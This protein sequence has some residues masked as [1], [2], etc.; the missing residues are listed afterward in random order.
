MRRRTKIVATL[1]PAVAS[2]EKVE[3]LIEAG[4]N[5]AR[6][7]CSHGDWESKREF[8]KWVR[9][10]DQG[11]SPVAILVDL[12]GPKFRI[13]QIQDGQIEVVAGDS[14]TIGPDPTATI[15]APESAVW[16]A[17]APGDRV[18]LG[19]GDVELRIE[20]DLGH[21]LQATVVTSGTIKSRQGVTLVG[22]SFDAPALTEKDLEDVRQ[23]V[24]F[25]ADYI[26]LSYVRSADDLRQ[27]RRVVEQYSDT[28]QIVA[29]VET[30][31]ALE[32][33][34]DVVDASD[35][36]MVARGDLGL[37][38]DIE[39]VPL[40]QKKIIACCNRLGKPVITATQM[41]ESM[42]DHARP[43]RAEVSDI[44]NAII[45][46]T[47]AVMLSGETA[48]GRFPIEAV[49]T[50]ARVAERTEEE[51]G[52]EPRA[53]MGAGRP[54]P[55]SSTEAVALAAVTLADALHVRAI[56]TA[57][58]TGTTSRL[59][60]KHRPKAP[61]LCAAFEESTQRQMALV[62]G[63]QSILMP[64]TTNTDEAVAFL[65]ESFVARG[66]LQR[67]DTYVVTSAYPPGTRGLT[68]MVLVR[69]A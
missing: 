20:T 58:T 42:L 25:G 22:K 2:P 56:L 24:H 16:D 60:S 11:F 27:L 49:R 45:D 13:G 5:V 62:W 29:K 36:V 7:N 39:D 32:T 40:A 1:G 26:A 18:L 21:H 44:A 66:V 69:Q 54:I 59:V 37:Q 31:E 50:M 14:L 57:S 67:G 4:M 52:H 46:G 41:L 30:P 6:L 55:D 19:D 9:E 63:V 3:L 38:M 35:A 34:G 33:I 23:A 53:W 15:Q 10:C 47:D 64:P 51:L 43:T 12:Q 17:M 28:I 65:S 48:S 8:V 61:I 68:N